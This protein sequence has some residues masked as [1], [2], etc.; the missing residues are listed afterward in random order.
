MSNSSHTQIEL[1]LVR[2]IASRKLRQYGK[3][4]SVIQEC[5]LFDQDHFVG[6]QY[7]AGPIRFVWKSA[8]SSAQILRDDL[9]IESVNLVPGREERRLA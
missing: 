8:E 9:L 6:M 4:V 3:D 7:N 1:Q 2:E 5:Y